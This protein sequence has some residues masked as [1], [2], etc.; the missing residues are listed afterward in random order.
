MASEGV[1]AQAMVIDRSATAW[2]VVVVLCIGARRKYALRYK[3][4]GDNQFIKWCGRE[5]VKEKERDA[6]VGDAFFRD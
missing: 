2:S 1:D 3:T 5:D 4:I 6:V